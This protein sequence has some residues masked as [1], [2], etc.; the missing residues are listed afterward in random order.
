MVSPAVVSLT[1][2]RPALA[3]H[4][5]HWHFVLLDSLALLTAERFDEAKRRHPGG[6]HRIAVLDARIAD[7]R[8]QLE[9]LGVSRG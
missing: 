7:R 2:C 5:E 6:R 1:D 9:A 4:D 8:R 3:P